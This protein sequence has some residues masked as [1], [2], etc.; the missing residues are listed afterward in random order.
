MAGERKVS[1]SW[2]MLMCTRSFWSEVELFLCVSQLSV[3]LSGTKST[4]V[5]RQPAPTRDASH[6]LQRKPC[7]WHAELLMFLVHANLFVQSYSSLDH[8][9]ITLSLCQRICTL[10]RIQLAEG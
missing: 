10:F 7:N 9:S 6:C 4:R 5:C 3:H 2:I 1:I 8:C